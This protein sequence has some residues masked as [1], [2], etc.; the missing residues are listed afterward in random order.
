[1]LTYNTNNFRDTEM[2]EVK[3]KVK[4]EEKIKMYLEDNG[5]SQTFVSK[6][7]GIDLPKL[8]LSLNGYRRMTFP[9][10]ELICGA[11]KVNTDKFLRPRVPEK[12]VV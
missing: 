7:T 3:F 9:E 10:Y 4:M 1:M 2:L 12:E 5:I 6:K 11:L 8:N